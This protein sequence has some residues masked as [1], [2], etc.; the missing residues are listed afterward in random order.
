M[1]E[2]EQWIHDHPE[3]MK[4]VSLSMTG[5]GISRAAHEEL[6]HILFGP[7]PEGSAA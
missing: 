1:D 7:R 4:S 3:E 6:L 5:P 2:V